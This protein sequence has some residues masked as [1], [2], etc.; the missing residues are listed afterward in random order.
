MEPARQQSARQL[1]LSGVK[2]I[3]DP[4]KAKMFK[5]SRAEAAHGLP[6]FGLSLAAERG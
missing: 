4:P 5:L 1:P 6:I 2:L 3:V